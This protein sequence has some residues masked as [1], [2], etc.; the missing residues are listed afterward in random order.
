VCKCSPTADGEGSLCVLVFF[1]FITCIL[2]KIH[3][4]ILTIYLEEPHLIDLLLLL[5]KIFENLFY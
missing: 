5:L 1:Y 4:L 2:I 3:K